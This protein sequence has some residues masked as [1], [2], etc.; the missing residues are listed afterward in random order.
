MGASGLSICLCDFP[1][2]VLDRSWF[3]YGPLHCR[4][5]YIF[6]FV[7]LILSCPLHP[8]LIRRHHLV[9][10]S[11]IRLPCDCFPSKGQ[12]FRLNHHLLCALGVGH[13]S[14]SA[15]V[16]ASEECGMACKLTG[17]GGGGCAITLLPSFRPL[18]SSASDTTVHVHAAPQTDP[19]A[20]S[21]K[22]SALEGALRAL[23]YD[24]FESSLAGEGVQ[25]P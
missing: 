20:G 2:L 1:M 3:Q 15:V 21:S 4:F 5:L 16:N 24:T 9:S 10:T 19:T 8:H 6:C 7:F 25:W 17:A 18:P 11:L 12:L 22:K 23:G 13:P 14:L